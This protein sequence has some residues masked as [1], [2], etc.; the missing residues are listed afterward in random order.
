MDIDAKID[1]LTDQVAELNVT[2]REHIVHCE[3]RFDTL[4]DLATDWWGNSK[5]GGK[6]ELASACRDLRAAKWLSG[7]V[8]IALIA[9]AIHRCVR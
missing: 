8:V 9:E 7:I 4:A 1:K 5:P 2:V 3:A 6:A